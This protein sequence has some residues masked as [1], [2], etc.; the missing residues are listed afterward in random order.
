MTDS[1][2]NVLA[3]IIAGDALGLSAAA[4]LL[5]AHRGDGRACPSTLWRWIR[6]GTRT[7]DGRVVRLEA[8]RIGTRW[9]TSR[10]AL[11]RYMAALTPAAPDAPTPDPTP[12][13]TQ[14]RRAHEAALNKLDRKLATARRK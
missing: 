11:A 12:T 3:E 9:L 14:R 4:R 2:P 10:A 1:T 6:T 5:P 13:A 7:P 8:A